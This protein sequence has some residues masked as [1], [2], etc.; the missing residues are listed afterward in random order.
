[1]GAPQYQ[2]RTGAA[3]SPAVVGR[4]QRLVLAPDR[5]VGTRRPAHVRLRPVFSRFGNPTDPLAV[6]GALYAFLGPRAGHGIVCAG[7]IVRGG[8]QA[9][10]R[11][12]G[13]DRQRTHAEAPGR[14]HGDLVD[15]ADVAS[16]RAATV[17]KAGT[18]LKDIT[19]KLRKTA[20]QTAIIYYGVFT[21]HQGH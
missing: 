19:P 7:E 14:G 17:L 20:V 4:G 10:V 1:R 5:A 15:I 12:A 6:S 11:R 9:G 2:S 16:Q 13:K 8:R 21:P 3:C 18:V